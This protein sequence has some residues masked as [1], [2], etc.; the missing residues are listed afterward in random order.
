MLRKL[1][2]RV[3]L[4]AL[5]NGV[6][7]TPIP[8]MYGTDEWSAANTE[9]PPSSDEFRCK[10]F[11]NGTSDCLQVWRNS[12]GRSLGTNVFNTPKRYGRYYRQSK[13]WGTVATPTFEPSVRNHKP[14][15]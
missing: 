2:A 14:I 10:R 9:T 5:A 11:L 12:Q 15:G 6:P 4:F 8:L 7:T 13:R 3:L 1:I